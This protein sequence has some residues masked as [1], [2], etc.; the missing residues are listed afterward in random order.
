MEIV[1]IIRDPDQFFEPAR[2][3]ID[4]FFLPSLGMISKQNWIKNEV[5]ILFNYNSLVFHNRLFKD[6]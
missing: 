5:Y 4:D 6:K 1:N 3:I 2:L